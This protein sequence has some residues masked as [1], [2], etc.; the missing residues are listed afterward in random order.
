MTQPI[1]QFGTSRFL[2]AHV[3]LFV[4][5]ALERGDT[6]AIG[7]IAVVQTTDNPDS[8]ARVA[9]L[10][11]GDGYTVRIRGIQGGNVIDTAQQ[12]R[13]IREAAQAT[14]DWPR[15][16]DAMCGPVRIVVSNTADRGYLLDERDEASLIG[17]PDR[18][19]QSFPAKLLV[20]LHARWQHIP[21]APLSI[22]PCELIE[23]NGDTLRDI[24]V[25]LGQRW[26]VSEAFIRYLTTHCVWINSL[27]DRIVPEPLHPAGAIAEPYALWA[28]ERKPGML[29]PCS[30]P[31]IVLTDDVDHYERLKLFLLNL[32]H[33]FLAERWLRDQRKPDETVLEAMN[34]PA[35]R[36]ELE[37][38]WRDEVVPV[39]DALGKHDDA[40]AYVATLRER[41]MNPLLVHRLADI[42][43]NHDTKKVRRF[44]PVVEMARSLGLSIEQTRLKTALADAATAPT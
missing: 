44:A 2:Q 8:A 40:I 1:L 27:V 23:K 12:C 28:V 6:D 22:F 39:F 42:A 24:V 34:D 43:R 5:D 4:S 25:G 9:A 38:L 11:S 35:L 16:R 29:M 18:V 41:F 26:S 19:P 7:G 15:V 31:D 10:S 21:D 37:A 14:R 30:H 36:G 3:D 20:L 32:G 33:T 13:A 17:S